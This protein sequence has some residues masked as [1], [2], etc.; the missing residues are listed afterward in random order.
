M[1]YVHL[2]TLFMVVPIFNSMARIDKSLLEAARDAGAGR[3][4]VVAEVVLPAVKTGIAL[5]SLFV[6][7][8]VMGDFFVVST[9][10]GGQSA[11][12]VSALQNEVAASALSAGGGECGHHGDHRHP[13][14]G[15]HPAHRRRAQ[16]TG[17]RGMRRR[18]TRPWTFYVF[19]AFFTLFVLFLYGPM[20]VD[21]ILSFQGPNG[22]LTF[23]LNG[24]S[25]HWFTALFAAPA[26]ATSPAPSC[27]RS[28][29]RHR[30]RGDGRALGA[31]RPCLPPSLLRLGLRS[32]ISPS[33][34]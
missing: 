3:W 25:L 29:S 2:F 11:S 22:G 7:T 32:S 13:D 5:G 9:M 31:G 30:R 17:G 14:G 28:R 24:F 15:G 34:A 12:V 20:I 8:L 33:P 6:V 21:L 18:R 27:A 16:G 1:A 19:A 10:S 23:P 26:S 4:G